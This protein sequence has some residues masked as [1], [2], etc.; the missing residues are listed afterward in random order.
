MSKQTTE[1]SPEVSNESQTG[2]RKPDFGAYNVKEGANGKAY[3]SQVGAAW[4]HKD[5]KG[6][7]LDLDSVPISGRVVLREL[8]DQRMDDYQKQQEAKA[9]NERDQSQDFERTQQHSHER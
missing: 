7:D 6:Y 1:Q 5:G 3:W 4:P 2:G 9:A 8:R